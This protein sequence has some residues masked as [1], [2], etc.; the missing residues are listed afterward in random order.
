MLHASGILSSSFAKPEQVM[1][2]M[3]KGRELGLPPMTA[4]AQIFVVEGKPFMSADLMKALV[5]RD[6]PQGRIFTKSSSPEGAIVVATRPGYPDRSFEFTISQAKSIKVKEGKSLAQ[7]NNWMNYPE[8]MCIHRATAIACREM[9]PDVILGC[10]CPQEMEEVLADARDVTPPPTTEKFN[11]PEYMPGLDQKR[12]TLDEYIDTTKGAKW[13]EELWI[14][15]ITN[16][17]DRGNVEWADKLEAALIERGLIKPP[18]ASPPEE[19]EIAKEETVLAETEKFP[20]E[21]GIT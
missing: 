20:F 10:Y 8:T 17:R 7:K 1:V 16:Y 19:V 12:L 18:K 4:L 13:C 3:L 21:R 15:Q 9:F 2:V 5:M 11:P 6:C 14:A